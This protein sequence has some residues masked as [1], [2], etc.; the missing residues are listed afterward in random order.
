M[1]HNLFLHSSLVTSRKVDL[2]NVGEVQLACR[3][4]NL[5]SALAL[6]FVFLINA[7]IVASFSRSFFDEQCA[8]KPGGPYA[9]LSSGECGEIG[10]ADSGAALSQVLG[11]AAKYVWA[12]GL[13]AAG[14][15]STLTGTVAGQVVMDGFLDLRMSPV[16]RLVLTRSLALIPSLFVAL[17]AASSDRLT[18]RVDEVLNVLQ[19]VQLPFAVVPLMRLTSRTDLMGDAFV[20]NAAVQ[21]LGA[22]LAA[23]V[24]GVNAA[25]V[26]D[27]LKD[28]FSGASAVAVAFT[29]LLGLVYVGFLAFV[30]YVPLDLTKFAQVRAARESSA[31]FQEP[32]IS[33]HAVA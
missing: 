2:G 12:F 32:L 1:P 30:A 11:G 19:S 14:Q 5:E 4:N 22:V 17:S 7:A 18:D 13:L 16:R 28:W 27:H 9:R 21:A 23:A 6:V 15:S 26:V 20:D 3:Y 8:A 31:S 29:A 24:L 10:L 33:G 25:L